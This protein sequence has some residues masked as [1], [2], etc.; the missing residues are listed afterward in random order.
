MGYDF[1]VKYKK[2]SENRVADALSRKGQEGGV[3]LMLIT[4]PTMEL[5]ND[6]KVACATNPQVQSL[7]SLVLENKLGTK[8][9]MRDGLLL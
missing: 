5:L 3:T 9:S 8:Y 7:I 6:L 2:G 1:V 4:F